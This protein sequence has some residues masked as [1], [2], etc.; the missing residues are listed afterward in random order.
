LLAVTSG[1]LNSLIQQKRY[2]TSDLV[3]ARPRNVFSRFMVS[4]QPDGLVGSKAMATGGLGAF[5][6]FVGVHAARLPA[7]SR[8]LS[9]AA[10]AILPAEPGK[11]DHA[12][13]LS[14]EAL[15][16][17]GVQSNGQQYVRV[18]PLLD[19]VAVPESLDPW[20]KGALDPSIFKGAIEERW[21]ALIT[22]ELRG[23]WWGKLLGWLGGLFSEGQVADFVIKKIDDALKEWDLVR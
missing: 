7:R 2:A 18:I 3:G 19:D 6:G 12:G 23:L 20:P 15:K 13:L 4:A 5:I 1:V 10:G 16:L 9:G 8:E 21:K 22:A 17:N 14:E 11:S